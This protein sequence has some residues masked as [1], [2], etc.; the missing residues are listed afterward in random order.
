MSIVLGTVEG[1]RRSRKLTQKQVCE[2]IGIS[3]QAY[4]NKENGKVEFTANEIGALA[5][6]LN[7]SPSKF[8]EE[9]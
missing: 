2:E 6:L 9:L 8:Y 4:N 7:V 3:Y 1:L 5:K